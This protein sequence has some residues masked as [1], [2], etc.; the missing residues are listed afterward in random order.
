MARNR[1]ARPQGERAFPVFRR[2]RE[3]VS[4]RSL[5]RHGVPLRHG[6]D[7]DAVGELVQIPVGDL[8]AET[9][10]SRRAAPRRSR[11]GSVPPFHHRLSARPVT[12]CLAVV[13]IR[14]SAVS[15]PLCPRT[16]CTASRGP[17]SPRGA[18]SEAS[19]EGTPRWGLSH[20]PTSTHSS[21]SSQQPQT[22]AHT[23][24]DANRSATDQATPSQQK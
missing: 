18:R 24:C 23:H 14:V 9:R 16:P 20:I 19:C 22:S 6:G 10:K 7:D 1:A 8:G 11:H 4:L 13:S 15:A 5:A 17:S 2:R 3:W 12:T 21:V